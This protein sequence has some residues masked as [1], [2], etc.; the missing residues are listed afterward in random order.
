MFPVEIVENIA[1]FLGPKDFYAFAK[2]D[3]SLMAK[4]D[5]T[6]VWIVEFPPVISWA[7]MQGSYV[8]YDKA[9][10]SIR[11]RGQTYKRSDGFYF[12]LNGNRLIRSDDKM[13]L[14]VE[15]LVVENPTPR[16]KGVCLGKAPPTDEQFIVATLQKWTYKTPRIKSSSLDGILKCDRE[17][18]EMWT[19]ICRE[20]DAMFGQ[21]E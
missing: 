5:T 19:I 9:N 20:M 8:P 11:Y 21:E 2:T 4:L 10:F 7:D 15:N 18:R 12:R 14:L 1:S 3:R 17:E 13:E 16:Q 6:D